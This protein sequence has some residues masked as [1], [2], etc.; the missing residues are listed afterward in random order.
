M[1]P[2]RRRNS[3]RVRK[4]WP[5]S[6]WILEQVLAKAEEAFSMNGKGGDRPDPSAESIQPEC[7]R[8]YHWL[9]FLPEHN[10]VLPRQRLD[11]FQPFE[12]LRGHFLAHLSF[13]HFVDF[14]DRHLGI[15]GSEL[16][17]DHPSAGLQRL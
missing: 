16:D 14:L 3:Q 15:F 12:W 13:G 9:N 17:E 1:I 10:D 5:R 11:R 2:R 4:H 7:N 6:L 8:R